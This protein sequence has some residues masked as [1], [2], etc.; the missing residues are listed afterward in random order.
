MFENSFCVALPSLKV[1]L[2]ETIDFISKNKDHTV[3][4]HC[5]SGM[6]ARLASSILANNGIENI[7][8]LNEL[9]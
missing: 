7:V 3:V 2:T 4:I 8:S 9:I 5:R 6:R 1:R